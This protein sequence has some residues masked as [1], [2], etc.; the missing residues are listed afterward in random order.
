[1]TY[2]ERSLGTAGVFLQSLKPIPSWQPTREAT[3]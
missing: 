1:M 3:G 2:R